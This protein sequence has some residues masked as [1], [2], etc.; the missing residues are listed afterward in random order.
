MRY[1]MARAEEM[2]REQAYRIYVTDALKA[3]LLGRNAQR[4]VDIFKPEEKRTAGEIIKGIRD[5]LG[6]E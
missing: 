2:Q 6:G 5:K 4:Y 3:G 1:V